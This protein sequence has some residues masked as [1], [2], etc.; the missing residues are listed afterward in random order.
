MEK[1]LILDFG[2]GYQ[3]LIAR[4]VRECSVFS[5]IRPYT[6]SAEEI[7]AEN[8]KGIIISGADDGAMPDQF[9]GKILELGLPILGIG[10]GARFIAEALGGGCTKASVVDGR[11]PLVVDNTCT[12]F[13]SLTGKPECYIN[14]DRIISRVPTG[15]RITAKTEH[16]PVAAAEN[17]ARRLYLI[18]FHPE[19]SETQQGLDMF[20]KFLYSVCGCH[21]EWTPASIVRKKVAELTE[22]IGER[23]VVIPL[24]GG[25]ASGVLAALLKK[26]VGDRLTCILIDNGLLRKDEAENTKTI[27]G[28]TEGINIKTISKS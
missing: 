17:A 9:D 4:R 12:A 23:R 27:F 19:R 5:E 28:T 26:A 22:S 25:A 1:I 16:C 15:F 2:G 10:F 18:Y 6:V 21:A 8:Y 7:E 13:D 24:S 11:V 3:R 20:K 14:Y